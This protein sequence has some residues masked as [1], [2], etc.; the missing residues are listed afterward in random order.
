M[1][2]MGQ[3]G[4]IPIRINR[5]KCACL[6]PI[7][8]YVLTSCNIVDKIRPELNQEELMCLFP[9][10]VVID[11][12]DTGPQNVDSDEPTA[13]DI[14]DS[15][16]ITEGSSLKEEGDPLN[17]YLLGDKIRVNPDS[18]APLR[19]TIVSGDSYAEYL[20]ICVYAEID[21][22]LQ[23]IPTE[24]RKDIYIRVMHSGYNS[25]ENSPRIQQNKVYDEKIS[26]G[27]TDVAGDSLADYAM[28]WIGEI[29]YN[30]NSIEGSRK[31]TQQLL[32]DTLRTT[33]PPISGV[34]WSNTD[35]TAASKVSKFPRAILA[36]WGNTRFNYSTLGEYQ[37]ALSSKVVGV[38]PNVF[39]R[40]YKSNSKFDN[41]VL[42]RASSRGTSRYTDSLT[43]GDVNLIF[44]GYNQYADK[45]VASFEKVYCEDSSMLYSHTG[46]YCR[47]LVFVATSPGKKLKDVLGDAEME[48]AKVVLNVLSPTQWQEIE[49]KIENVSIIPAGS[50]GVD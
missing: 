29:P 49:T 11:F 30:Q 32:E 38:V 43:S 28:K 13:G 36:M 20:R 1:Q 12:S 41:I 24:N 7:A 40:V 8:V 21:K 16:A 42:N 23:T 15:D 2:D 9:E 45:D 17:N 34:S 46:G 18:F 4:N 33:M 19:E 35:W 22:I 26:Y 47:T 37:D 6:A 3:F 50:K 10:S 14:L 25:I 48:V 27:I 5:F 31:F 39:L 44:T